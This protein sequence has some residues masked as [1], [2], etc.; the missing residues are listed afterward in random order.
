L[1]GSPVGKVK[2]SITLSEALFA[3]V[4]RLSPNVSR[5]VEAA[6]A[7]YAARER[8]R[9]ALAVSEGAWSDEGRGPFSDIPDDVRKM[10][11]TWERKF[12]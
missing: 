5:F 6:V 2:V 8:R 10:R 11:E 12:E 9:R 7:E 4:R 3:E 1:E